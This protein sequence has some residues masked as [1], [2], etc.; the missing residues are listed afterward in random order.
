MRC[1]LAKLILP[2]CLGSVAAV[3]VH[4]ARGQDCAGLSGSA[5]TDCYLTRSRILG[6]QSDI[7]ASSARLRTSAERL[8]AV[9]GGSYDPMRPKATKPIKAHSAKS[10]HSIHSR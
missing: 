5:R 1:S 4:E 6:E 9:T 3:P 8:R 2:I 7:A 10:K